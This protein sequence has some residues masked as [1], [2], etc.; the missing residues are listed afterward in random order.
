MADVYCKREGTMADVYDTKC[1]HCAR[2]GRAC[3]RHHEKMTTCP[4][5]GD[6]FDPDNIDWT[7]YPK[8]RKIF[9]HRPVV[10]VYWQE[11]MHLAHELVS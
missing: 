3:G 9:E 5:C 11:L 7:H 10:N 4:V 2:L 8:L 1:G 6:Y